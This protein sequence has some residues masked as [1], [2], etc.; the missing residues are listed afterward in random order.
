MYNSKCKS[1]FLPVRYVRQHEASYSI[2]LSIEFQSL[3]FKSDISCE[4]IPISIVGN[5]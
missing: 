3:V 5:H 2:S 1:T 4:W